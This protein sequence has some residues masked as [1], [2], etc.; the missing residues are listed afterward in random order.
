MKA[1][2]P[3]NTKTVQAVAKMYILLFA[4]LAEQYGAARFHLALKAFATRYAGSVA[5]ADDIILSLS[6]SLGKD[7]SPFF[8]AWLSA[9]VPLQ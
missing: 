6:T 1:S 7:L 9:T 5:S 4:T 3:A 2:R 8:H